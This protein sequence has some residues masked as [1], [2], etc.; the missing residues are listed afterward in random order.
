M[1]HPMKSLP[2]V[3]LLSL[4]LDRQHAADTDQ[5]WKPHFFIIRSTY[6]LNNIKF[7]DKNDVATGPPTPDGN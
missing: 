2:R 7:E 5:R 6:C 3:Y 4:P 1:L